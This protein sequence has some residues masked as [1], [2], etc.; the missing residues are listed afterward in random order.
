MVSDKNKTVKKQ[1]KKGKMMEYILETTNLTKTFGKKKA[2][3]NVSIHVGEGDIYGL[4][5]R[6]G[7]GKTTLMKITGGLAHPTSGTYSMF[8]KTGREMSAYAK[9]RGILIEDPGLLMDCNGIENLWLKCIALGIKDKKEPKKLMEMV[10]LGDVP[11]LK[12]KKYS[13]GMKQRLGLALAL[14]GNPELVILDEPIN[15]FD[16]QGITSIRELITAKQKE[17]VT[18][19]ISSHILGELSKI[20]TKYGFINN[21]KIIEESTT[22]ELLDKCK[23]KIE[24]IPS[25]VP[26]ACTI[27]EKI[28]FKDYKVLENGVINIY[29]QLDRTGDITNALAAESIATIEITKKYEELEDYYVQLVNGKEGQQ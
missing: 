4:V 17:G 5:G 8:G 2:L 18:F 24:L 12:T 3:D 20:A 19:I 21:G 22:K 1:L 27:I 29:E 11:K 10:G 7:A 25:D 6:N 14:V 26:K 13:F 28:G 23:S 9:K 15:G 16:P